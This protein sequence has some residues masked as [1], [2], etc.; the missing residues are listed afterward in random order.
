MMTSHKE[1]FKY[2]SSSSCFQ[3]ATADVSDYRCAFQRDYCTSQRDRLFTV[4]LPWV[5]IFFFSFEL[6]SCLFLKH[7][8]SFCESEAND[9]WI[10]LH[11]C[12]LNCYL[13]AI[14][15]LPSWK[16]CICNCL[17]VTRLGLCLL[18]CFF[19]VLLRDTQFRSLGLAR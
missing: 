18:F 15:L 10:L 16:C 1:F 2:L 19:V 11:W 7:S 6:S 5:F 9:E 8:F 12:L 14:F 4:Y 17:L 3:K 13:E